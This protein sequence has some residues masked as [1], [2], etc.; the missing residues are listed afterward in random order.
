MSGAGLHLASKQRVARSN[1]AGR[2]TFSTSLRLTVPGLSAARP[3]H[4]T[5]AT[6]AASVDPADAQETARGGS[7]ALTPDLLISD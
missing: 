4:G 5:Y 1:R 2:A 3:F 7:M 6:P